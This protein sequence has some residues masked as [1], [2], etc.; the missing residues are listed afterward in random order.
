MCSELRILLSL[1]HHRS[2]L[3]GFL[4]TKPPA[5]GHRRVA[6]PAVLATPRCQSIVSTTSHPLLAPGLRD[7]P[8]PPTIIGKKLL[9]VLPPHM[10]PWGFL[11]ITRV[12]GAACLSPVVLTAL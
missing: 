7:G 10:A 8:V 11:K 6:F 5:A 4:I 9:Q 1:A 3:I 2:Y 12:L